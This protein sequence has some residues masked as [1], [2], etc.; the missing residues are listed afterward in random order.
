MLSSAIFTGTPYVP[1][2][3]FLFPT[4]RRVVDQTGANFMNGIFV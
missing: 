4:F 1:V 2:C 3:D